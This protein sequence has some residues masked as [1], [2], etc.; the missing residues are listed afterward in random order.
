MTPSGQ[1]AMPSS[2]AHTGATEEQMATGLGSTF[3][4]MGPSRQHSQCSYCHPLHTHKC[5]LPASSSGTASH[6]KFREVLSGTEQGLQLIRIALIPTC[7]MLHHIKSAA[8]RWLT[9]RRVQAVWSLR[10]ELHSLTSGPHSAFPAMEKLQV[11]LRGRGSHLPF[12]WQIS[13]APRNF[14]HVTVFLE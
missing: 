5:P 4:L 2:P 12:H 10:T 11:A 9:F 7:R 13:P 6:K 8:C 3:L 1:T 14:Q